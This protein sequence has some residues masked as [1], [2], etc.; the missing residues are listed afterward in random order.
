[1]TGHNITSDTRQNLNTSLYALIAIPADASNVGALLYHSVAST[2]VAFLSYSNLS[3]N[4]RC[5]R[6]RGGSENIW[7]S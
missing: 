6:D 2:N 4:I 5:A 3:H 1:M 7:A